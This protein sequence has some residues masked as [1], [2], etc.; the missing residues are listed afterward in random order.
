MQALTG[1]SFLIKKKFLK[2]LGSDFRI[3][4]AQQKEIMF[5]HLKAFKFKEDITLYTDEA[6]TDGIINIKAR[7][8]IDF[9][10]AYDFFDIK[11]GR[12][13]GAA[14]R[15]GW[16]SML[17]DE[18]QLMDANDQEIGIIQEDSTLMAIL[19]RF[20]TALI[21]QTFYT[22]INGENVCRYKNNFNP[23]LSRVQIDINKPSEQFTPMFAIAMGIL[24]CAIEGKQG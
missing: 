18:W 15:K 6:K 23:F 17:Q 7:Q 4:D 20:V 9:S 19:R 2:L 1:N 3:Y 8:I 13:I 14:K 12:K 11:T 10:A 21:P 5:A 22:K 16:K 24:L